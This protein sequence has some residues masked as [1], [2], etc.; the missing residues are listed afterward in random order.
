MLPDLQRRRATL[1]RTGTRVALLLA[2][3][4]CWL[5]ICRISPAAQA[6]A[7]DYRRMSVAA[8]RAMEAGRYPD[9]ISLYRRLVKLLPDHPGMVLNLG[10]ALHLAGDYDEA[11]RWLD[12]AAHLRPGQ[13]VVWLLLGSDLLRL[14]RREESLEP[15]ERAVERKPDDALPHL[16]LATALLELR[17]FDRS[18]E[19]AWRA[20][21]LAPRNP[22]AWHV[23]AMSELA[24]FRAASRLL[25]ETASDSPYWHALL[26]RSH[27]EAAR[28]G[29]ACHHYKLALSR[30]PEMAI[31][32]AALEKIYRESGHPDW[33]EAAAAKKRAAGSPDCR[34]RRL[35]CAFSAGRY[36]DVL[37]AAK[38]KRSPEALYWVA[39]VRSARALQ[40]LSRLSEL[41]PSVELYLVRAEAFG[42]RKMYT[43]AVAELERARA[44]APQDRR[45]QEAMA[46]Y[47]WR[48]RDFEA[49][50]TLLDKLVRESP[51]SPV[52]NYQL[53]DCLLR[54]HRAAEAIPY[55]AAAVKAAPDDLAARAGLG[56]A[57]LSSGKPELAVPHL[58]ASLSIDRLGSLHYQL[59][60]AYLA[61]GQPEKARPVLERYRE[62]RKAVQARDAANIGALSITPP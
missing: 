57:Y 55:L 49:A 33:A 41:P 60:R 23:A 20:A 62:I 37:T 61:I 48:G 34:S 24:L 8:R 36:E 11:V 12:K 42:I 6:Q 59:A 38:G 53:G 13:E 30:L 58:E 19:E 28:Y 9:A 25:E 26:A 52:L 35:E 44:L 22:R 31:W 1:E 17:R 27:A 54:L 15:L 21:R 51:D 32:W 47:L 50:A 14:G 18:N 40:A 56:Q 3:T 2:G 29:K 10:L 4:L 16:L 45:V 7:P 39:R 43:M 46:E 5:L